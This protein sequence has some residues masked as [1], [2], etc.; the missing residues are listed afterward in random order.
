MINYPSSEASSNDNNNPPSNNNN[1]PPSNK[2]NDNTR[3]IVGI[4][5]HIA[6]EATNFRLHGPPVLTYAWG[7]HAVSRIFTRN[8]AYGLY[9]EM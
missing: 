3:L 2:K 6:V 9:I 7:E 1:N 5:V 8:L 4:L